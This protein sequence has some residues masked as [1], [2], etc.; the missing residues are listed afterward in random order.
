MDMR[1]I[2]HSELLTDAV[3]ES[4]VGCALDRLRSRLW[5]DLLEWNVRES[6]QHTAEN[7]LLEIV[8]RLLPAS[9]DLYSHLHAT[10]YRLFATFKIDTE[11][12]HVAII[13]RPW[14]RLDPRRR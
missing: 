12:N 14:F 9:V 1:H 4:F 2:E 7:D 5:V 10:E 13:D 8:W 3:S 11:L 6:E